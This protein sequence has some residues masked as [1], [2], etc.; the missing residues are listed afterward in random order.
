MIRSLTQRLS[1]ILAALALGLLLAAG[2]A[3]IS[4]PA[5]A[6][7]EK[8]RQS[9]QAQCA[10]FPKVAWWGAMS[11]DR[12]VRYVN[13]KHKGDWNRYIAKWEKQL[14]IMTDIYDRDS[15]A[16]IRKRGV[17]LRGESLGDYISQIVDRISVTRC[18]AGRTRG[19]RTS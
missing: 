8:V 12:V 13:R 1:T 5:A 10:A 4:G 15:T 19:G 2:S 11:H 14:K 6:A 7:E 17:S 9:A 3:G 18:L 16:V